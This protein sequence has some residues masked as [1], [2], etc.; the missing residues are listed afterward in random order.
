MEATEPVVEAEHLLLAVP[1]ALIRVEP[2]RVTDETM[3]SELPQPLAHL[4]V[5]SRDRPALGGGDHL[6]R[7]EAK[8]GH[9]GVPARA[10]RVIIGSSPQRVGRILDYHHAGPERLPDLADRSGEAGK[11]D[12]NDDLRPVGDRSRDCRGADVPSL[13]LNVGKARRRPEVGAAVGTG[14]KGDR[15][16]E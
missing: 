4:G 8:G 13:S 9:V 16:G 14:G 7:V 1:A 10:D 5:A 6:Q 12:G 3:V 11:V 15:T 2:L